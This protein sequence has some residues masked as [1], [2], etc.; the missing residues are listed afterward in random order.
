M[1]NQLGGNNASRFRASLSHSTRHRLILTARKQTGEHLNKLVA[2][3]FE[4][5]DDAFFE[6]ADVLS[7]D[8]MQSGFIYSIRELKQVRESVADNFVRQVQKNLDAF[9]ATESV[10]IRKRADIFHQLDKK[11]GVLALM[12]HTELE[13]DLAVCTVIAKG[14][15]RYQNALQQLNVLWASFTGGEV[16]TNSKNP[17]GPCVLANQFRVALAIWPGDHIVKPVVYDV[18]YE[19]VIARLGELYQGLIDDMRGAGVQPVDS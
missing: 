18:F 8:L 9:F 17:V 11:S 15:Q 1:K 14:E 2:G 10:A 16:T 13:E 3:L 12:N 5:L 6:P 7:S 4:H 19:Y